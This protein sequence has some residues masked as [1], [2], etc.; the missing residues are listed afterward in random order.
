MGSHAARAGPR[1]LKKKGGSLLF[2]ALLVAA[3]A[4]AEAQDVGRG[5]R[6]LSR[7]SLEIALSPDL[8]G[9]EGEVQQRVER[10]LREQPAA[11]ALDRDSAQTLRLVAMVRAESASELRGFWLP[12]SGT[13]AIGFVRL[14]VTRALTLPGPTPAT[15]TTVP[16]IVWHQDRLIARSW[17]QAGA[18]VVGAVEELTRA[19]LEEYRRAHGVR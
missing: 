7:V 13:Y 12:F 16:A 1:D 4:G 10:A 6:G 2:V 3:F 11:P 8:V 14:E 19:F 18:E 15:S 17:R 9:M 5:L